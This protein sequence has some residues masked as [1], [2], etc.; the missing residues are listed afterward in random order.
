MTL[1]VLLQAGDSAALIFK[2]SNFMH[3]TKMITI[4]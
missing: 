3:P 4:N 1:M 2:I